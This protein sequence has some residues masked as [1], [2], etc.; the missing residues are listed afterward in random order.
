VL[1]RFEEIEEG[2]ADLGGGHGTVKRREEGVFLSPWKGKR[3]GWNSGGTWAWGHGDKGVSASIEYGVSSM[4]EIQFELPRWSV[5][6]FTRK[7][8]GKVSIAY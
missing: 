2:L 5:G 4:G 7:V 6:Q 3:E 1:L 8:L